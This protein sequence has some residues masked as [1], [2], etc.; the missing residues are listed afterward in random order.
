[1]PPVMRTAEAMATQTGLSQ[2]AATDGHA[3]FGKWQV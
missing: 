3:L 2:G 1:M